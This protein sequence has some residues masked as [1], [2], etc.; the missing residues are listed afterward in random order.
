MKY[1]MDR[2]DWMCEQTGYSTYDLLLEE[3]TDEEYEALEDEYYEYLDECAEEENL[4]D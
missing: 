3:L 1:V 2:I 4:Y